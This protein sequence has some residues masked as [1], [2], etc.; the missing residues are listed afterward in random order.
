MSIRPT[1][2]LSL[3]LAGA[4]LTLGA[5][6]ASSPRDDG[7]N[8]AAPDEFRVVTKAPL[9]LPPDYNLRPPQAGQAQ[10]AEVDPRLTE[11]VAAFG[12]NIGSGASASERALVAAAGANAVSPVIRAQV[13]WEEARMIR[14]SPSLADRILFWQGNEEELQ[15]AANDSAT[16]G[17]DVEI[18]RGESGGGFKLPGT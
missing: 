15:E 11:Q 10:P 6:C 16:G 4:A 8:T 17:A 14:K 18:A 7:I 3:L 12:T 1:R 5:G 2:P 9:T 13:D